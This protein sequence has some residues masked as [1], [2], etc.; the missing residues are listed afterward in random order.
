MK[1]VLNPL[2][3]DLQAHICKQETSYNLQNFQFVKTGTHNAVFLV[4]IYFSTPVGSLRY[5]PFFE[6]PLALPEIVSKGPMQGQHGILCEA[7]PIRSGVAVP[8]SKLA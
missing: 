5:W 4:K 3:A 8:V 2:K 7:N 1:R 6:V